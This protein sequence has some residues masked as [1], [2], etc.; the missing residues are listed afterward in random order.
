MAM[1]PR[2]PEI[3]AAQMTDAQK[4]VVAERAAG[5]IASIAGPAIPLLRSPELMRRMQRVGEHLRT[6][7]AVGL[8]LHAL[9]ILIAARHC[10]Q[11]YIWDYWH[12]LAL[13]AGLS[14]E[15]TQAIA[16]GRRPEGSVTDEGMLYDLV[17]ELLTNKSVSDS[18]YDRAV[19]QFGEQ[20]IVDAVAAVG[21]FSTLAMVMNV[22]RTPL[23][24]GRSPALAP[25]AG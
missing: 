24:E 16:E 6:H 25:L 13:K 7:S 17:A 18:T 3:P 21:Y 23:P 10:T 22:A 20:G 2:M 15:L 8:R 19:A 14:L 12:P 5:P 4:H 9:A 1:K 11:Q